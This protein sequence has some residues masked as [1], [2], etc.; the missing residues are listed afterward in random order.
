MRRNAKAILQF[1]PE[2]A[3]QAV[4]IAQCASKV[5]FAG[6]ITVDYPNSS[7]AKKKEN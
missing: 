6:G 5:G 2:N 7:K 1:Y 4:L 3:E